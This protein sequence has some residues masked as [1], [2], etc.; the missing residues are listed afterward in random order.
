M[1]RIFTHILLVS[2]LAITLVGIGAF[3]LVQ[4]AENGVD[5]IQLQFEYP[6][7]ITTGGKKL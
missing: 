7:G 2:M 6:G 3:Q 1:K 5:D 4:A